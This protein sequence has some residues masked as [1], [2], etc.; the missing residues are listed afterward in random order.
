MTTL[1]LTGSTGHIGGAVARL[2][3]ADGIATRL[4]AREPRRAP[5]LPGAEVVR[6]EYAGSGTV[7][8]LRG[9]GTLLMVSAHES[10]DRVKLHAALVEA[11]VEAGVRHVV[12]TSFVGAGDA[13][14]F[15]LGRDHGATE[16]II[17]RSG[18]DHTFLRDNFYAEVFPE[19]AGEDGA[20]RGPAGEGRVAAVSRRDVAEVAALVL[21]EPAAHSG[22]SYD[23]TGP[24]ALTLPEI[25]DVLTRV[26]GRPHRFV[27]ETIEEA[28][29]SREGYGAPD[30]LVDAWISTY[31]AIRDGEL[32]HVS[33][34]VPR[35]LGRPATSFADAVAP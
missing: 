11:A 28:R 14:G 3:A 6:A 20:I 8:A 4:L 24:E 1:A 22:Q 19:F 13:S 10:A 34:D 32:E 9:V 15:L 30:W 23:L 25:A 29:R 2:L 17:E 5:E 27:D 26:T 12:Y 35:L 7:E 21:R 31:T 18:L 33:D 16:Q